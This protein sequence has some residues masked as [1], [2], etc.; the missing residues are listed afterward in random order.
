[1][2]SAKNILNAKM[3]RAVVDNAE[4][5]IN[6]FDSKGR[7]IFV[8]P[9]YYHLAGKVPGTKFTPKL[10]SG[11]HKKKGDYVTKKVMEAI[12]TGKATEIHN[13]FY[14]SRFKKTRRYFDYMIGP[15]RDEK[16]EIIGAYSMVKDVT[17]RYLARR[18][19]M[20]LNAELEKKVRA[21]TEKLEKMNKKLK[22]ISEE[23][24]TIVSDIAHEI[25]TILTVIKGNFE[26]MDI[27]KNAKDPFELECNNEIEKEIKKMSKIASDLVFIV[28]SK[29]YAKL[30]KMGHFNVIQLLKE[31]VRN[32]RMPVGNKFKINLINKLRSKKLTTIKADK[33]KILTLF[34][35]L[36]ENAVKFGREDGHLEITVH[37]DKSMIYIDFKDDGIGIEREKIDFI[38]SP[39]YQTDKSRAMRNSKYERGFGLGLAICNKIV[40][41]HGGNIAANSQGPNM[42]TTV[43]VALPSSKRG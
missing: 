7:R 8:N 38:F 16:G 13:S 27:K 19:L 36:I 21:R 9:F 17:A 29:E 20:R 2:K 5:S 43:V 15:L 14:K 31:A 23:K 4:I 10:Y 18:K 41:A 42:G 30:F 33:S 24:N 35:N 37:R 32:R 26:M 22:N 39:F 12:G 1:M 40:S 3:L 11:G 28:K 25:K 6:V 34:G